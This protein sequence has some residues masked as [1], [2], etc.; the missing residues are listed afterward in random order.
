MNEDQTTRVL[1][2]ERYTLTEDDKKLLK[3]LPYHFSGKSGEF[4]RSFCGNISNMNTISWKQYVVFRSLKQQRKT[5]CLPKERKVTNRDW[6]LS[7]SDGWGY[8]S[9]TSDYGG[10]WEMGLNE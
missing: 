7:S 6:S 1:P 2:G 8:M 4:V 5:M 10:Y 9:D 3:D